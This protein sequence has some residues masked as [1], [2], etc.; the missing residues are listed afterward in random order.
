MSFTQAAIPETDHELSQRV[1]LFLSGR[2]QPALRN[3]EVAARSGT[4]HLRGQVRTFYHRQLALELTRR[5]AGVLQ[6]VDE[7]SVD[8]PEP[9]KEA[10][11]ST[12][13]FITGLQVLP[14]A[15]SA[16]TQV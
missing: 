11:V 7:L 16:M 5:V 4:V 14:S 8:D 12:A 3:L 10:V 2:S 6:I 15:P 1:Q 9:T 13:T